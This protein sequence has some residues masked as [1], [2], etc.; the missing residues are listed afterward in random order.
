MRLICTAHLLD[1]NCSS[2]G[3]QVRVGDPGELL[4]D[5]LQQVLCD[6][7]TLICTDALL[8]GEPA[9]RYDLQFTIY[10]RKKVYALHILVWDVMLST[11][12]VAQC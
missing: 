7:E 1:G 3:P 5:G 12:G 8:R 2:E 6:V 9:C 4:L 10:G 11:H